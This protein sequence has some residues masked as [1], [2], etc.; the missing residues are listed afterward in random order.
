MGLLSPTGDYIYDDDGTE[1]E[2]YET[3]D[4]EFYTL[5]NGGVIGAFK[6]GGQM[7]VIPEGA[8]HAHK[9][10]MEG[11]G[12]DF[13]MKGIPVM[14]NDGNQVAE[15]EREELI[16][17][18]ENTDKI[19]DL[20]KKFYSDDLTEQ[21]KDELA[22]KAGKRLAKELIENVD[23]RVGLIDKIDNGN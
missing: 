14:D 19:E 5:K 8:L 17:N 9:N 13:T 4:G 18:K 7:N 23:D 22:I 12:K 16:L 11:A 3:P 10:H 15:V 2:I 20:Y 1:H 6:Q 21:E